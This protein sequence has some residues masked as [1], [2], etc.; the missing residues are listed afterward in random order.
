MTRTVTIA[1]AALTILAVMAAA[2]PALQQLGAPGG[3]EVTLSAGGSKALV[4]QQQS[5]HLLAGANRLTFTWATDKLDASSVRLQAGEGLTAGEA[6]RPAGADKAVAWE[7]TAPAERDWT[8]TVSYLLADLKWSPSY[9]LYCT[10]GAEHA[11]LVGYLT[12]SNE[13]G[14]PLEEMSLKLALGRVGAAGGDAG[15]SQTIF[16]VPDVTEL[17]AGQRVRARF[18][19]PMALSVQPVFRIDGARDPGQV[20]QVLVVQPPSEGALAQEPLPTGPV[21]VVMPGLARDSGP[22][23]TVTEELKYRPSEEFELDLGL[24]RDVVV[25]RTMTDQSRQ[26]LDFDRLGRVAGF[27]T[28]ERY[29]LL[30]RNHRPEDVTLEVIEPVLE[31]WEFVSRDLYAR[32]LDQAVVV[33]RPTVAAGE[34]RALHFTLVKHSGTRIPKKP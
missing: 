3:T 8:V 17:P 14:L 1:C 7:V 15:A 28:V 2:E 5:V 9:L 23:A 33:M 29:Q 21:T 12:L 25:E 16:T 19:T 26:N 22:P 30:I 4:R 10:P 34:E 32:D 20:R 18:L 27:D 31:T 11:T 24:E 6:T 13:S